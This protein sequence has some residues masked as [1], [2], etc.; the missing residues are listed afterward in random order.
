MQGIGEMSEGNNMNNIKDKIMKLYHAHPVLSVIITVLVIAMLP[1]LFT[2]A[3]DVL[4]A[5]IGM[6]LLICV[7]YALIRFFINADILDGMNSDNNSENN[8]KNTEK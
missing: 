3:T 4:T 6:A 1:S 8:D 5:V 2:L 7:C